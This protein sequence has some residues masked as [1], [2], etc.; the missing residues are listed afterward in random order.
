MILGGG[1]SGLYSAYQLIYNVS[2][3]SD[4]NNV[5]PN[6]LILEK[7]KRRWIGGRMGYYSFHGIDVSI[8]C[9]IGR[10][11]KD[12]L[13]P[14]HHHPLPPLSQNTTLEPLRV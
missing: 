11:K 14:P 10:K 6:I 5:A 8:G 12:K 13:F 1:I 2:G 7:N 9:G 4:S 3:N